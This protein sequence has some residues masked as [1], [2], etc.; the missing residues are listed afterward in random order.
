MCLGI[1]GRVVERVEGFGDQLALVTVA[2]VPRRINVGLLDD[3]AFEVGSWVIIHMGFALEVVDETAADQAREGLE[4]LGRADPGPGATD[5][6]DRS[7]LD[8]N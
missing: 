3:G 5:S 8:T 7:D 4:L 6:A 2:G 1:P